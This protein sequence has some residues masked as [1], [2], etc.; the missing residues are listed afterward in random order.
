MLIEIVVI[1][2]FLPA[3]VSDV[4]LLPSPLLG[5]VDVLMDLLCVSTADSTVKAN[6]ARFM[7]WKKGAVTNDINMLDIFTANPF[8]VAIY[9][10]S[11]VQTSRTG[12]SGNL[13]LLVQ[14]KFLN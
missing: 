2:A 10:S 13:N 5:N 8:Y 9:L 3:Y 4:Q 7:L 6:Y 12:S 11:L 14:I 1:H